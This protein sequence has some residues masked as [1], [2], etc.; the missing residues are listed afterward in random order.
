MSTTDSEQMI[1][2]NTRQTVSIQ[3]EIM[4]AV[5]N[6]LLA[7]IDRSPEEYATL[8]ATFQVSRI[9]SDAL[10]NWLA[11]EE[12]G[13]HDPVQPLI[14]V[15]DVS[16][17]LDERGDDWL[18]RNGF[19][20]EIQRD[21]ERSGYV[22]CMFV[23]NDHF[24]EVGFTGWKPGSAHSQFRKN[25]ETQGYKKY[26]FKTLPDD[27][28]TFVAERVTPSEWRSKLLTGVSAYTDQVKIWV[29]DEDQE[30]PMTIGE[31]FKNVVYQTFNSKE[32][33]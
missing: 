25:M 5:E 16:K 15:E 14:V 3:I 2:S 11:D 23:D 27:V 17:I 30:K 4:T 26:D 12:D 10:K 24:S 28:Q 33:V 1:A 7:R 18:K 21:E 9:Q 19:I 32:F 31:V 29:R 22:R 6:A 8:A 13:H 20:V